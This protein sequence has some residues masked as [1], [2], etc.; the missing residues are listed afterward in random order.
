LVVFL[1]GAKDR[2]DDLSKLLSW[3]FP[4]FVAQAEELPYHWLAIQIPE[5]T[6]WP[7]WQEELFSLV[8]VLYPEHGAS[9]VTLSGFS[10]GSAGAWR[11]AAAH[12][13]RVSALAIVSGKLPDTVTPAVLS[14]LEHV[15]TWIF[16]GGQDGKTPVSQAIAAYEILQQIGTPSRL[17]LIP[18]GDHFIADKVY[19]SKAIQLWLASPDKSIFPAEA[20][21]GSADGSQTRPIPVAV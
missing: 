14:G 19:G 6:T 11:I 5:E 13:E 9:S 17:T 15:P 3:G 8:D 16:H 1:H 12:P 10:L 2:G 18:D 20:I 21:P 4:K 7:D